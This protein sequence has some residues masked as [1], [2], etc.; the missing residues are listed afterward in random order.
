MLE[1]PSETE[2]GPTKQLP[3]AVPELAGVRKDA[4]LVVL[5]VLALLL[6]MLG[7]AFTIDDPLFLWLGQHIQTDPLDFFGFD[8]NW[9]G[10]TM[11]MHEVTKNPPITGYLIAATAWLH[12][13]REVG[14]H[15]VFLLPAV[16]AALGTWSLARRLSTRPVAAAVLSVV[17]PVFLVSATNVMS[18][19]LML[20]LW[21]WSLRFWLE[22]MDFERDR[23]LW[24]SALLTAL[25]GLTKYFA[26]ALLP[27]LFVYGVVR[28]GRLGKWVL[29]LLLPIA[30][31]VAYDLL[32]QAHYGRGMISDAAHYATGGGPG[33]DGIIARGWI[34]LGFAG[35]CLLPALIF[36]PLLWSRRAVGAGLALTLCCFALVVTRDQFLGVATEQSGYLTAQR[37]LMIAGGVSLLA[38][39]A[40][41]LRSGVRDP[42]R[43][44]LVLWLL[45]TFVFATFVNWVNNGRSNLPMAPVSGILIV[46]HLSR[47]G[48]SGSLWRGRAHVALVPTMLIAWLVAYGDAHWANVVRESAEKTVARYGVGPGRLLYEGHWG[49]QYYM[50]AGGAIAAE[51]RSEV[52]QAGDRLALP[53]SNVDVVPPQK[54]PNRITP[55][56]QI[57]VE[58]SSWL[59]QTVSRFLRINFYAANMGALPFAFGPAPPEI[60]VVLRALDTVELGAQPR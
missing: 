59:P 29:P 12:G 14:L 31:F 18:D 39:V 25:A 9:Y 10:W 54:D 23:S 40:S 50:D 43:W 17:T 37:V 44:L 3:Q 7:K 42:D 38:L 35:G 60:V 28:K 13:Y 15:A 58:N 27:L 46:R 6:P 11:P 34:G 41:E 16:A 2:T 8:V 36:A 55:L 5:L 26:I 53:I 30:V 47:V 19:V 20:A 4:L 33:R 48:Y 52:L 49:F 22:G 51:T 56:Q 57:N 24:I 1:R 21:C 45:G 32:T